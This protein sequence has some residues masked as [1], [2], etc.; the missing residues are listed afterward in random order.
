MIHQSK[1]DI[2]LFHFMQEEYTHQRNTVKDHFNEKARKTFREQTNKGEPHLFSRINLAPLFQEAGSPGKKFTKE[3]LTKFLKKN[4]AFKLEKPED[5]TKLVDAWSKRHDPPIHSES[6]LFTLKLEPAL[7]E[8]LVYLYAD[9]KKPLSS[10]IC[11]QPKNEKTLCIYLTKKEI[12]YALFENKEEGDRFAEERVQIYK[13]LKATPKNL[14]DDFKIKQ[15]E[16]LKQLSHQGDNASSIN[17]QI[18][19]TNP[20]SP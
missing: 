9:R 19:S 8:L 11:I 1:Q 18:S 2:T 5:L 20:R 4:Y 6:D 17:F 10:F 3:L 12:L 16:R 15:V 14:K 13:T 7:Q